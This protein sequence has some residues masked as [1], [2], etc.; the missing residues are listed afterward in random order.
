[1]VHWMAALSHV[2]LASAGLSC[3]FSVDINKL[4]T[5][6]NSRIIMAGGF[7]IYDL[8]ALKTERAVQYHNG[9]PLPIVPCV[10]RG[11]EHGSWVT[12]DD[13]FPSLPALTA[14]S[15]VA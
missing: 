1:V 15:E 5:H 14:S 12:K 7:L 6:S 4:L 3:L 9:T 13:P 11:N 8:F 2:T 10:Y